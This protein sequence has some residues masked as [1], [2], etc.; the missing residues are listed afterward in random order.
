M[1]RAI[2]V[3]ARA[4][5][6][7]VDVDVGARGGVNDVSRSSCPYHPFYSRPHP[8]P[9]VMVTVSHPLRALF[10]HTDPH[11]WCRFQGRALVRTPWPCRQAPGHVVV[12]VVVKVEVAVVL[13]LS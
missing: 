11:S 10:R 4:V 2:L 12:V 1:R 5:G 6:T 3:T 13:S 9:V 7:G 8:V